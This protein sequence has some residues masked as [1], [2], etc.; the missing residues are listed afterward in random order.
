MERANV[1]EFYEIYKG[2]V[3]E[4]MVSISLQRICLKIKYD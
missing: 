4:Y 1:E 3:A 2:V